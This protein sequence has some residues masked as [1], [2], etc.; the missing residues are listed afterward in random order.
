M[1]TDYITKS[2]AELEE[3]WR[4]IDKRYNDAD[5]LRACADELA[6][7]RAQVD[8]AIAALR[9]PMACGHPKACLQ[10]TVESYA[11]R[12]LDDT[13][14]PV[15]TCTACE[16]ER[17]DAYVQE[18]VAEAVLAESEWWDKNHGAQHDGNWK[19]IAE[20]RIASNRRAAQHPSGKS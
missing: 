19:R 6:A 16:H 20:K 3:K 4:S 13:L 14:N 2:L 8:E 17:L 11:A 5:Q 9:E 7:V 1:P 18:K 10:E 12:G 15:V